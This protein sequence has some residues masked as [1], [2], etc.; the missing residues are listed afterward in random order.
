MTSPISSA[1]STTALAKSG[2]GAKNDAFSMETFMKLIAAQ[3]S[4]QDP[5]NPQSQ[6]DMIA[7]MAQFTSLQALQSINEQMKAS[8]T[9]QAAALLGNTVS[10]KD[11][12]GFSAEGTVT[13]VLTADPASGLPLRVVVNGT[14]TIP[15]AD[16]KEITKPS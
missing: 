14:T 16:V 2:T 10:Y 8:Q 11:A 12:N 13:R 1:F 5:M 3:M 15:F 7:Q 4:N 6:T 9:T